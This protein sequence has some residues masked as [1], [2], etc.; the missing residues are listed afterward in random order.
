MTVLFNGPVP[1]AGISIPTS[2]KFGSGIPPKL[3]LH[4][5][6]TWGS[7]GTSIDAYIQTSFDQGATWCDI[8]EF[9]WTTSSARKVFSLSR[10]TPVTSVATP[11]DGSLASNT[12]VDGLIGPLIRLNL[13]V[14]GNYLTST[15]RIDASSEADLV[16]MA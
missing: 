13:K 11:T 4:G 3:A 2:L 1:A 10:M 16:A 14:V 7:G 15:L 6:L 5:N 12:A 9:N 8:A